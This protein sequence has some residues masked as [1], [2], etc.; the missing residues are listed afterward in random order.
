MQDNKGNSL[1][2]M[3]VATMMFTDVSELNLE[4]ITD[5]ENA[6]DDYWVHPACNDC[7]SIP[8][9]GLAGCRVALIAASGTRPADDGELGLGER[10]P[11]GEE[12]GNGRVHAGHPSVGD[13]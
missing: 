10:R 4:N 6:A 2:D 5:I 7:V 3:P 9:I 12:P 8:A 1:G 11:V 13:R